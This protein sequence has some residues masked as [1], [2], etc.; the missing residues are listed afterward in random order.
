MLADD[1]W[2]WLWP[3]SGCCFCC[4]LSNDMC[5]PTNY[6]VHVT[7]RSLAYLLATATQQRI[8]NQSKY[9]YLS[10]ILLINCALLPLLSLSPFLFN[11]LISPPFVLDVLFV[12]FHWY[13]LSSSLSFCQN[14]DV[15]TAIAGY[16]W[17]YTGAPGIID[18]I[19]T[20]VCRT[21]RN[22]ISIKLISFYPVF[23]SI[24]MFLLKY[25]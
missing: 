8:I 5:V 3:T 7:S 1:R 17:S 14:D 2:L 15:N 4:W 20:D 6:L 11:P 22:Y 12:F 9:F 13:A 21:D 10:N 19:S 24:Q 16:R 23:A 18:V 25:W